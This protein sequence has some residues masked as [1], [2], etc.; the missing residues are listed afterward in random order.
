MSEA[1][2]A[3]LTDARFA[4]PEAWDPVQYVEGNFLV[5]GRKGNATAKFS[6]A[7]RPYQRPIIQ[8]FADPEVEKITI[9]AATQVG[10]TTLGHVFIFLCVKTRPRDFLWAV[11]ELKLRK[12]AAKRLRKI[13]LGNPRL[14]E[15]LA[16][17]GRALGMETIRFRRMELHF[18]LMSSENDMSSTPAGAMGLDELDKAKGHTEREGSPIAQLEDRARTFPGETTILEMSSP[19]DAESMIW[20]EYRLSDMCVWAVPCPAC[21]HRTAW[22]WSDI[23]WKEREAGDSLLEHSRKIKRDPQSAWWQCPKCGV[24]VAGQIAKNEMNRCGTV[25]ATSESFNHRGIHLPSLCAP[26]TTF[27][28]LA[29]KFLHA[30]H[31]EEKGNL[32][33]LRNFTQH[34]LA[35]PFEAKKFAIKEGE[36]LARV[37]RSIQRGTLPEGIAFVTAGIDV[38][39][40]GFYWT[41][42]G[43]KWDGPTMYVLDHGYQEGKLRDHAQDVVLHHRLGPEIVFIDS[44]GNRED[45]ASASMTIDCYRFCNQHRLCFPTK[46]ASHHLP[47]GKYIVA[48]SPGGKSSARKKRERRGERGDEGKL[49]LIDSHRIKDLL[50]AW[51]G[52][53]ADAPDAVRFHDGV[54]DDPEFAEQMVVWERVTVKAKTFWRCKEGRKDD[55][56]PDSVVLGIAGALRLGIVSRRGRDRTR[57]VTAKRIASIEAAT[58]PRAPDALPVQSSDDAMRAPREQPAAIQTGRAF[59]RT[60]APE[61]W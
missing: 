29:A 50:A 8:W 48:A 60:N 38:Q 31:E 41:I 22:E 59:G 1:P 52:R 26:E 11:P 34:E 36:V 7:D 55:H 4:A 24:Q 17:G 19:T 33:P 20:A 16:G 56:Y 25:V 27:H 12:K 45:E 2:L 30:K 53:P 3:S 54:A 47:G 13:I 21:N 15:E 37:D 43:F 10:K 51:M 28:K 57:D 39:R 49:Q 61:G 42:L 18:I 40:H 32:E 46:G 9:V 14:K 35:R 6:T 44:G 58:T 5:E 23:H